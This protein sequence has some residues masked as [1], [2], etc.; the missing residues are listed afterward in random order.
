MNHDWTGKPKLYI[1]PYYHYDGRE[2]AGWFGVFPWGGEFVG[3]VRKMALLDLPLEWWHR[4]MRG[5][6]Q[7]VKLIPWR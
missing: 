5:L 3:T 4:Y 2:E 1:A 6:H 7:R